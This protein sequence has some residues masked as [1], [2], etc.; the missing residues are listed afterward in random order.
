MDY[1][2]HTHTYRCHHAGG[3]PEEYVQRAIENG[4]K[5]MG[6]S[7]HI[8]Y[9]PKVG[10]Q[11]RY[12]MHIDEVAEYALEISSL[13]EKYAG[14]I[15]MFDNPRDSFGISLTRLGYSMNSDNEKEW[16]EAAKALS[17]QKPIVQAYVMDAIFD[18][19]EAGEAWIAPYYAGDAFVIQESNPDIKF[20]I[21]KEGT[22]LFV[23]SMCILKTSEHKKEAELFINFMCE[24]EIAAMNAA[25][26]GYA[27]PN[28]EAEKLLDP[29]ITENKIVYPDEDYLKQNTE[30]FINLP[31]K[32]QMLQSTLWTDLKIISAEEGSESAIDWIDAFCIAVI[33]VCGISAVYFF[34]RNSKRRKLW[35]Q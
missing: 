7:E 28:T 17:E 3:T 25:T 34:I 32:T 4:I 14:K 8:P 9:L 18:K 20:Y 24:P 12:R 33:A 2:Y 26:V 29:A 22:N 23:D 13:R 27:T 35:N 5:H 6:F 31:Q 30:V 10:E 1:N 16:Q 21:A 11:S 19:M 15:L